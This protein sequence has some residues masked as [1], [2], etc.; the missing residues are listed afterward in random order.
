MKIK[1]K[2]RQEFVVGGWAEGR[3]G[4]AGGLGSL[5]LGVMK[6]GP[7]GGE[8]VP[9]GSVGSGL[10]DRERQWWKEQLELDA[11]NESPFASPVGEHGRTFH[12]SQPT[13]V[14]EVAFG[15]WTE[16]GHLRHP[17]YLGRRN[18]KDP[19]DVVREV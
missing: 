16:D 10:N 1:P 6:S 5:L 2:R 4:N 13:H 19:T 7:D 17:V 8:L 11:V 3:D 15:D 14:V 9:A 18:D 12:W